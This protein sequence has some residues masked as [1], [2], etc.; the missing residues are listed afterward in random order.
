MFPNFWRR[1]FGQASDQTFTQLNLRNSS[2]QPR[3]RVI[4]EPGKAAQEQFNEYN[5]ITRTL[6]QE[7]RYRDALVYAS[8]SVSLA[9]T[10]VDGRLLSPHYWRRW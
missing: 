2:D 7:E 1:L 10:G 5:A 6:C 9:Q 4:E 8:L 3:E